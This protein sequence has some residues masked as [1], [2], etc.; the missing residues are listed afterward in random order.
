MP[1]RPK[2]Q[3]FLRSALTSADEPCGKNAARM[4]LR[5]IGARERSTSEARLTALLV[6]ASL[7]VLVFRIDEMHVPLADDA[8]ISIAYGRTFW[9]G[10]GF[11][12]TP[13]SQVTEAY[14]NPLWTLMVGLP[15]ALGLPA[16]RAAAAMGI[17][18]SLVAL[19]I[20]VAWGPGPTDRPLQ[21]EDALPAVVACCATP[22]V[23]WSSAGLEGPLLT[24]TIA[25]TGLAAMREARSGRP[26]FTG[27]GLGLL[28]LVRPE[29]AL[30]AASIALP[31]L[32]W[33]RKLGRP[34]LTTAAVALGIALGGLV[35]RYAIFASWLPN[36]FYVKHL[37]FTQHMPFLETYVENNVAVI[38][39]LALGL[40]LAPLAIKA[41]SDRVVATIATLLGASAV[42]LVVDAGG[43][44]MRE[45]RFFGPVL[46][47]VLLVPAATIR[48]LRARA[49]TRPRTD[50]ERAGVRWRAAAMVTVI[51][52]GA[53]VGQT[54][55]AAERL[56]DIHTNPTFPAWLTIS[57]WTPVMRYYASIGIR[58]PRLGLSDIGGP[59]LRW[60]ELTMV[61]LAG[62]GDWTI[63]RSGRHDR[64]NVED[65][66]LHE[67]PPTLIDTHGPSAILGNLPV[68]GSQYELIEQYVPE[69]RT[70]SWIRTI[71]GLTTDAD[72]RCPGGLP[73]VRAM[74]PSALADAIDAQIEAGE[75]ETA[76]RL[77]RCARERRDDDTMPT[78]ARMRAAWQRAIEARDD[79]DRTDRI[80]RALRY[81]SLA[82]VLAGD[83]AHLRRETELLRA[84][85]IPQSNTHWLV[86]DRD[87]P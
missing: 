20:V 32:A 81:S 14:S 73:A 30:Y 49:L 77:Y 1:R 42:A 48:G 74:S 79:A 2:T 66:L 21:L 69:L 34:E 12:L 87:P 41:P 71:R 35:V 25:L 70:Y 60:P 56:R 28:T 86:H 61:D 15:A 5:W 82:T 47:F 65:Y 3:L 55:Q 45:W 52:A 10:H 13:F 19:P 80:E 8:A 84:R 72:P 23:Y 4:R 36:P 83:D 50:S 18:C 40:L 67:V 76:L 39:L 63:A 43:D 26:R 78:A 6:V 27:I 54:T 51:L 57:F 46:P 38:V 53:H 17:T 64:A 31:I 7:G 22:Y 75:P 85:F 68:F 62:L 58:H 44:W 9:T 11:R 37:L 33:R 29:G 24:L 59:S 16:M